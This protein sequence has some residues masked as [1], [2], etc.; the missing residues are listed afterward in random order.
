[1]RHVIFGA[2]NIGEVRYRSH[3][4]EIAAV[5][6]NS[7]EKQGG[8]FH[9]LPIIS[10]ETYRREE[11][12]R[13][14]PIFITT[15]HWAEIERQLQENGIHH[16]QLAPEIYADVNAPVDPDII[17]EKWPAYLKKLCDRPGCEVLEVGS[18]MVTG[19]YFRDYFQEAAY[20][21]FDFYPGKN[22]DVVGD[23]HRLSSYFDKKF[24]LIF[25]S[26]VFEHFFMPWKVS[27]EMIKLL[28]PGG[29]VF[30]ETHFAQGRHEMPWHFF[31]FTEN[32]LDV[33]FPEAFGMKCVKKSVFNLLEGRFSETEQTS[34]YLRGQMMANLY[35]HTE[36]LGRKVADLP[37]EALSWDRVGPE[38]L[39]RGTVYPQPENGPA[40]G[41][42]F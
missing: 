8:S 9:G 34:P 35:C 25:S 3:A 17:H 37:E 4:G 39:A 32:G 19:D 20:T 18:R 29:Y 6:D 28:K 30:V 14:L 41:A 11:A 27:V 13:A 2:G 38:D 16:Y 15:Y 40:D 7:P 23:A 21:G 26:A 33:L 12:Y 31:H 1:M 5:I 22:V 42:D 36:Y 10:L 24:D